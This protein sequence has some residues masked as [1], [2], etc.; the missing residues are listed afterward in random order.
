MKTTTKT[1]KS[2]MN[3]IV[4]LLKA[5]RIGNLISNVGMIA[6]TVSAVSYVA[7][8]IIWDDEINSFWGRLLSLDSTVYARNALDASTNLFFGSLALMIISVMFTAKFED[9]VRE[10]ILAIKDEI[11]EKTF[12]RLIMFWGT[13]K[14][15]AFREDGSCDPEKVEEGFAPL[16]AEKLGLDKKAPE[17][18]APEVKQQEVNNVTPAP[19]A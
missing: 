19:A 1:Q 3:S 7:I 2:E 10:K 13:L 12:K 16:T 18:K 9:I 8:G 11:G 5:I 6:F 4:R 14:D 17:V 15:E